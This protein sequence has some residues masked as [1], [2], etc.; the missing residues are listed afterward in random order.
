MSAGTIHEGLWARAMAES[1]GQEARCKAVYIR[2][3]VTELSQA[4]G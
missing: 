1:D 2:L 4:G 3:R